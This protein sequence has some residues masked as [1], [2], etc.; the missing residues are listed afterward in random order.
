M[1]APGTIDVHAHY[2]PESYRAVLAR[3]GH[4]RPDGMPAIPEWSAA[5]HVATMDRLGIDVSLLSVSTPGVHLGADVDAVALARE[6]NEEGRRA[7]VDHPGRFGLLGSLPI[8]DLDA[9]M[10]EIAH[11][12]EV[13]D[14]DGFVLLT[15]VDGT[16]LGDPSLEPVLD[17][18]D[19]RG[20]PVLVHPTSPVCWEHTSFDRP[21]PMLEFLFDT[22]RAVV[23]LVLDGTIAR[24][25]N[26]RLIVPH[27]GATLPVIAD[28]VAGFSLLLDVDP[29]VDVLRDLAGLHYDLSGTPIPRQLPA[30]L[31]LTDPTHLHYGSDV[32]FTPDFVAEIA[33][34]ALRAHGDLLPGLRAN[35]EA[36]FP[37]LEGARP[38]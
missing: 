25:P 24:H 5:E 22:T 10:A 18:L 12:V 20:R 13:L 26:L 38:S 36:L 31:S 29:S 21:R 11:C 3:S 1:T 30:L 32:P 9:A 16:Y 19:R 23:N 8:G 17:E 27:A 34:H 28:R 2:L 4:D 35:T 33:V 37:R 15:N 14:V 7:V 6:V